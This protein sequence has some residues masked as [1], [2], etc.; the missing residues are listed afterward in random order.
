MSRLV[1]GKLSGSYRLRDSTN[2]IRNLFHNFK[3]IFIKITIFY[4]S[5]TYYF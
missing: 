4:K 2:R 3:E 5:I 1:A